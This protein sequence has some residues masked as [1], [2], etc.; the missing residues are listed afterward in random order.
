MKCDK[1]YKSIVVLPIAIFLILNTVNGQV[2]LDT[3]KV[4]KT[5]TLSNP[6]CKLTNYEKQYIFTNVDVLASFK[7]S[8]EKW[9]EYAQNN[10]D[11]KSVLEKLPDTL[12]YFQDSIFVKFIVTK[13]GQVC[14]IKIQKGNQILG[15]P[16]IKLL[17][18]SAQWQP[19]SDEGRNL[20]AYRTLKIQ[21]LIDRLKNEFKIIRNFKS[22]FNPSG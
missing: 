5:K 1:V 17:E 21:V 20:N 3:Q 11:F 19:A 14:D 16:V 4:A 13:A 6:E 7:N 12:Q 18:M 2:M 15:G 22:Y 10:F 8:S 9:F